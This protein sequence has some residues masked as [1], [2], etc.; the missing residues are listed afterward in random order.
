MDAGYGN[1]KGGYTDLAFSIVPTQLS[2]DGIRNVI[3]FAKKNNIFP[4]I[5]ELEQAGRALEIVLSLN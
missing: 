4:S 2:Y 1:V 5:G 3:S